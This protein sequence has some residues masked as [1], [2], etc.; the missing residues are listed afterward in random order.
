MN[1]N[2]VSTLGDSA[3]SVLYKIDTQ[4]FEAA[5]SSSGRASGLN[6]I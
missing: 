1:F 2:L 6:L 3:T 5:F 4:A